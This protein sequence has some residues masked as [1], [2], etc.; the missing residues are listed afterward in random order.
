[1]NTDGQGFAGRGDEFGQEVTFGDQLPLM[2]TRA[3]PALIRNQARHFQTVCT[4]Q[5][6]C[7]CFHGAGELCF[8]RKA[9]VG[10]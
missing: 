7:R 6:A 5:P 10:S 2:P 8:W 4:V 3:T 1:M 9:G